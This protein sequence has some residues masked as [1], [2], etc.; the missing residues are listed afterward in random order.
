MK[1]TLFLAAAGAAAVAWPGAFTASAAPRTRFISHRGESM[2]APENTLAAFQRAVDDGADGFE[3]DVYLT[4]DGGLI[5]LHDGTAKRT[6]GVDL[7]PCDAALAELRA[8][9]AGSWKGPQFKGEKLPTLAEALAL[10]RDNFEIYVEIKCGKEILPS[11][12]EVMAAEPKATPER[13]LFICFNADV[14][15]AV[16]ER[17]PAYRAYWLAGTGP[18]KDGTPGPTAAEI[19][20]KAKACNASGVDL[21]D[22]ADIT[23]ECVSAV[24]AAGLGFH[25]WTVN[26]APRA[27]E[28][29]AMGVETVTS[30]SGAGLRQAVYGAGND[31]MTGSRNDG[32]DVKPTL[33]LTFD[34]G[35]AEGHSGKGLLLDGEHAAAGARK[36]LGLRGTVALWFKPEAFYD[37]NTVFDNDV[38]P[39]RWEMWIDKAGTLK[40][41]LAG[42]QVSCDL[43]ALGGAGRWYHLAVTWD[44]LDERKV[45]LYVG[46]EEKAVSEGWSWAAPG[47]TFF[48]GGG[49]PGNRKG[50][51]VADD[52][53]VY[54]V[55]LTA[56]QVKS[57]AGRPLDQR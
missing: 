12:A 9:D 40:F 38:D 13:V 35:N 5:C 11:L 43:A 49:N 20:A 15:G 31:R 56:A 22:S 29:A 2:L 16:R 4:K 7:K 14:I 30:D 27:R 1:K 52:V 18:K 44:A 42:D 55:P 26:R 48:I 50:K 39:N 21:S 37:F 34:D 36:Q 32:M 28:L 57:L 54:D 3:L 17:F 25:I 24:K 46:G 19:I 10:A 6:T 41:R 8:L 53:L 47:G 23:P 33:H 45:R 51:G